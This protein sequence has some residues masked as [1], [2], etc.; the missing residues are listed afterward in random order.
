MTT[1]TV[2]IVD[3]LTGDQEFDSPETLSAF[4]LGLMLFIVT[5]VLNT[6]SLMVVRR[7]HEKYD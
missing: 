6:V 5:L 7:F 4:G 3:A 2:R 1:V